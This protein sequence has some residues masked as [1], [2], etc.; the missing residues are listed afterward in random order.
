M[1][2][3]Y[4]QTQ[5]DRN[6]LH[7]IKM[8]ANWNGH[9]LRRNCLQKQVIQGKIQGG[10]E[11]TGRRGRR[12]KHLLDDFKQK[13]GYCKLKEKTLHHTLWRTRFGSGRGTVVRQTKEWRGSRS[14]APLILK[15]GLRW[16]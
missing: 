9:I 14:I 4:K 15:L 13:T 16:E 6:I 3:C 5:E 7:E 12:S 2:R 1:K 11:E 8:K 10:K